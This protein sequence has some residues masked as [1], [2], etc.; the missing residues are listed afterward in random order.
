[1]N[2]AAV[3]RRLE[4]LAHLPDDV[5]RGARVELAH[6]VEQ[7]TEVLAVQVLA[8]DVRTPVRGAMHVVDADDVRMP[9]TARR[10]GLALETRDD[11]GLPRELVVEHL[12]REAL[13]TEPRV[14]RLVHAPHAAFTDHA[15]D[16]IRVTERRTDERILAV[17]LGIGERRRI[18]RADL[19]IDGIASTARGAHARQGRRRGDLRAGIARR[20]R[21]LHCGVLLS[22]GALRRGPADARHPRDRSVIARSGSPESQ[23]PCK[24][25][26]PPA[27]HR[28]KPWFPMV[29]GAGPARDR[30]GPEARSLPAPG[31]RSR[32]AAS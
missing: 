9:D 13:V 16:L 21:G 12:D 29:M 4:R 25:R 32:L 6:A 24:L 28:I 10:L 19:E 31:G 26:V 11:L 17:L 23:A 20:A 3:V 8:D 30:T 27:D 5:H 15:D 14:A 1:M 2:D 22:R 7:G 18:M